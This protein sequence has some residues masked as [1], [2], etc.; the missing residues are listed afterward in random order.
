M[1]YQLNN[2]EGESLGIIEPIMTEKPSVEYFNKI[3]EE[4]FESW[5]EFHLLAEHDEDPED[6][7]DFIEWHNENREVQIDRCFIE[8]IN[9]E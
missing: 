5:N 7:D 6:V 8:E 9:P 4:I 2:S 3:K 1:I